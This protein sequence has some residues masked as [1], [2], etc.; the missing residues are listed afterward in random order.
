M[1]FPFE[2][3]RGGQKQLYEDTLKAINENK[4]LMAYAPTGIGKTAAVLTA[5][6]EKQFEN[7]EGIVFFLT[8][9]H[10]QHNIAIETLKRIKENNNIDI[11]VIDIINKKDMCPLNPDIN[12]MEFE[13][14]CYAMRRQGTCKYGKVNPLAVDALSRNVYHVEEAIDISKVYGSCP[15]Y[16]ALARFK[17]ADVIIS[18]YSYVFNP[19]I[20]EVVLTKALKSFDDFIIIVDEAHNLPNRIQDY[21]SY[22]LTP[23]LLHLSKKLSKEVLRDKLLTNEI[24]ALLKIIKTDTESEVL[25]NDIINWINDIF[26]QEFIGDVNYDTFLTHIE[27]SAEDF[28][29]MTKDPMPNVFDSIASFFRSW[30]IDLKDYVRIANP[31]GIHM[32]PLDIT[33]LSTEVLDNV[34]SS[35]LMSATL[36]P[37]DMYADILGITNPM[38]KSYRSPFPENNRITVVVGDVST[39]Y[40]RRNENMYI[41]Y[42]E[43]IKKIEQ[44]I[45]GNV[46]IFFPSYDLMN[47]I[48]EHVDTDREIIVE[49]QEWDKNE[50]KKLLEDTEKKRN[51]LLCFV[52]G[53]G[54]WENKK[55]LLT[56]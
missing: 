35:V 19:R 3:I 14:Y 27:E 16:T 9:R 6:V 26:S 38:I 11:N 5:A 18:D 17:T 45:P 55:D 53:D 13:S 44:V 24:N 22:S 50:K 46:A 31:N 39:V 20:R 36:Y 40:R 23:G 43:W 21:G 28:K 10:S 2:N 7:R 8:S 51:L 12:R 29:I 41:K 56:C 1:K 15:Y 32:I 25:K 30:E 37:Q 54:I 4:T 33:P 42:A 34:R 52:Q 47:K 49:L 48:I